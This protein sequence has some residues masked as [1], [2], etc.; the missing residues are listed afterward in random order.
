MQW[1]IVNKV[2]GI[3]PV[4]HLWRLNPTLNWNKITEAKF[5]KGLAIN[6]WPRKFCHEA[7]KPFTWYIIP[8]GFCL[9]TLDTTSIAIWTTFWKQNRGIHAFLLASIS[10]KFMMRRWKEPIESQQLQ[11]S[12]E[13]S[14]EQSDF[15][16]GL[17]ITDFS[18]AF[19][20]GHIH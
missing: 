10:F 19:W 11:P 12:T 2:S 18:H 14:S 20:E 9:H 5:R 4:C 3:S 6:W 1:G 7:K 17:L 16:P 13:G 8:L 15:L